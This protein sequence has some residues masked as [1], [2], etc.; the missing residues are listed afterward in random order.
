MLKNYTK[1]EYAK[2]Y[3]ELVEILKHIPKSDLNK[4]PKEKVQYYIENQ[5]NNYEF[6]YNIKLN[7]EEQN[8]TKLTK[9]LIAN[10][11]IE[12]WADNEEKQQIKKNDEKELY[13][14]ESKKRE[15]YPVENIFKTKKKTSKENSQET[16]LTTIKKKNILEKML[17]KIK[18]KLKLT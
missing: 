3:K 13:I 15:L 10:L 4:I 18:E 9:I 12:Y 2:S 6:I 17:I 5:D 8:I 14:I 7:F 16:S 11:Y 1:E